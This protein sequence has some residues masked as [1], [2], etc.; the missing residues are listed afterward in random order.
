MGKLCG[1]ATVCF[2]VSPFGY[3]L[4]LKAFIEP[5]PSSRAHGPSSGHLNADTA[6]DLRRGVPEFTKETLS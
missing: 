2:A 6:P 4:Q 3:Y 1:L 5:T